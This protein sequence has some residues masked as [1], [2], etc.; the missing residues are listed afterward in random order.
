MLLPGSATRP[1][2]ALPWYYD[3]YTRPAAI[4][5][6]NTPGLIPVFEGEVELVRIMLPLHVESQGP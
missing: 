1:F 6:E 2:W 4:L 5:T 3:V